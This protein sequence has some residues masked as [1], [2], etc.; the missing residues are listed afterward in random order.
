MIDPPAEIS[1]RPF[2]QDHKPMKLIYRP[3]GLAIGI[4]AGF[5]SKKLFEAVWG[6]FDEE[7]PPKPVTHQATWPKILAAAAVQGIVFKVVRAGVDRAGAKG[8]N[9]FTGFWPGPEKTE[10][11]QAA[12]AVR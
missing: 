11:S 3:F 1:P 6:V 12:E 10:K 2:D 4:L 8:F 7:E 9:Y 5:V